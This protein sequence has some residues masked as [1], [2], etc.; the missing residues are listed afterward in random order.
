[1]QFEN[2]LNYLAEYFNDHQLFNHQI[3]EKKVKTVGISDHG[4]I[5]VDLWGDQSYTDMFDYYHQL[6]QKLFTQAE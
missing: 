2:D 1:A 3:K 5:Q 4:D 6:Y